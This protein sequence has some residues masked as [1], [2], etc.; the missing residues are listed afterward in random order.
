[1]RIAFSILLT[2]IPTLVCLFY[3][4]HC[5]GQA[6]LLVL[7]DLCVQWTVA[8][9]ED[10][11]SV[12]ALIASEL[13]HLSTSGCMQLLMVVH[14][15]LFVDCVLSPMIQAGSY[16]PAAATAVG[17][18]YDLIRSVY[19]HSMDARLLAQLGL[20]EALGGGAASRLGG[21]GSKT[22]TSRTTELANHEGRGLLTGLSDPSHSPSRDGRGG[23]PLPL[24]EVLEYNMGVKFSS[25]LLTSFPA[26][27]YHI[28]VSPFL[29]E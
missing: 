11:E 28:L 15:D 25:G 13:S 6:A 3:S 14:K 17:S 29:D 5:A 1:M 12:S 23:R 4:R 7:G 9:H 16:S 10:D 8:T 24:R 26:V 2:V 18:L 21:A 20:L 27:A 19:T 22:I